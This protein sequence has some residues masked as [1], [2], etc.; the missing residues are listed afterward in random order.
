MDA[1]ISA[2]LY[3][4]VED[5][6]W[7]FKALA[8]EAFP[9]GIWQAL[10]CVTKRKGKDNEAFVQRSATDPLARQ[11]KLLDLEDNIPAR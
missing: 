9:A 10:D 8:A 1:R 11:V 3:D 7:T 4:V 5:T 6:A 2:I